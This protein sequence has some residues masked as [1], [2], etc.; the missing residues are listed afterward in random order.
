M[1]TYTLAP[2][3]IA[4]G[5]DR[6]RGR[7]FRDEDYDSRWSPPVGRESQCG[8]RMDDD[9]LCSRCLHNKARWRESCGTAEIRGGNQDWWGRVDDPMPA[10]APTLAGKN[11]VTE[12]KPCWVSA[13]A[14]APAETVESL[15]ATL[16]TLKAECAKASFDFDCLVEEEDEWPRES[17]SEDLY[18]RFR[19]EQSNLQQLNKAIKEGS[20][21]PPAPAAAVPAEPET[22]ESL[23]VKVADMRKK[24]DGSKRSL[25]EMRAEG[26]VISKAVKKAFADVREKIAVAQEHLALRAENAAL[27]VVAATTNAEIGAL[28]A[29]I[30]ALEEEIEDADSL[31]RSLT[32]QLAGEVARAN[33]SDFNCCAFEHEIKHL[34]SELEE[35][36]AAKRQFSEDLELVAT[37]NMN[38]ERR[39]DEQAETID[40]LRQRLDD[41]STAKLL[42]GDDLAAAL[43]RAEADAAKYRDLFNHLND[44]AWSYG[45]TIATLREQIVSQQDLI[46]ERDEARAEVAALRESVAVAD[47][48]VDEACEESAD[49]QRALAHG[50]DRETELEA[51]RD[52]WRGRFKDL[53]RLV[54]ETLAEVEPIL[55][56]EE[57]MPA[58]VVLRTLSV[59]K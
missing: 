32:D 24:R 57:T 42:F 11:W 6:C 5:V 16:T 44:R 27:K 23:R 53:R 54:V 50:D 59:L 40:G 18:E 12:K 26:W 8:G 10:R 52:L 1:V 33:E 9:Y 21:L 14:P 3:E 17:E 41:V 46:R 29:R 15:T 30:A 37:S 22:V 38:L 48:E 35:A 2:T 34:R 4:Y 20:I 45:S 51:E 49:F 47:H 31:N 39:C 43:S 19:E 56:R 36:F 58:G 28:R 25:D 55:L 7:F 13:H